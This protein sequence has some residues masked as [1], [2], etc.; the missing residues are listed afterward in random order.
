MGYTALDPQT[1]LVALD[2]AILL[3]HLDGLI[4]GAPGWGECKRR[5]LAPYHRKYVSSEVAIID[6]SQPTE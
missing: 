1:Q 5:L 3:L 4:A 2:A 6:L